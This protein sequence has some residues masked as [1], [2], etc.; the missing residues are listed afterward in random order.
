MSHA[1]AQYSPQCTNGFSRSQGLGPS[2]SAM[3]KP[4]SSSL[5]R[6]VPYFSTKR[7][8]NSRTLACRIWSFSPGSGWSKP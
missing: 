8:W 1:V 4:P 2:G 3:L 5:Q 6:T 7:F